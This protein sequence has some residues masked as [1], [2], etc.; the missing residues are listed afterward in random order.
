MF[1]S[2]LE[3]LITERDRYKE[4]LD[5]LNKLRSNIV[6][7]QSASWSNSMYPL[8]AILNRSGF[9][10][11]EN[12]EPEEMADHM[13]GYGGAGGSPSHVTPTCRK[14]DLWQQ[15]FEWAKEKGTALQRL[16]KGQ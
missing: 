16:R 11:I 15:S 8:V 4:A 13:M 7:T 10:L 9:E 12:V 5:E 14:G 3:E 1:N 2:F 6:A